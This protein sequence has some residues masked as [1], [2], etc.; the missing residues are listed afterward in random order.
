MQQKGTAMLTATIRYVL[1]SLLLMWMSAAAPAATLTVNCGGHTGFGSINAALKALQAVELRGPNT[2]NVSGACHENV[3]VQNLNDLTLNGLRGASITDASF[4][5]AEVLD[6]VDSRGFTLNGFTIASTCPAG[7]TAPDAI[8]CYYGS[9]CV[10]IQNTISGASGGSGIGVYALSRVRVVGGAVHD[11]ATGLFATDSGQMMALGVNVRGN[12]QGAALIRG[13]SLLF[14]GSEDH[15][16]PGVIANNQA[17][18]IDATDGSTVTVAGPSSITGNGAEGVHLD[19]GSKL[20]LATY[21]APVSV[22]G[23][24]GAGV[25]LDDLSTARFTGTA[26]VSGNG[27]PDIAC[28]APTAVTR[29]A[30][31]AAGG[32]AHTNCAN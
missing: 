14:G 16:T 25:S 11:N 17:Q 4:G 19:L 5:V 20:V 30:L 18:G 24:A 29:R 28:N 8:S 13:G 3:V 7:C 22:S 2:V 12:G 1:A 15:L 21:Y 6:V 27:Q 32:A 9:D 23:N 10:L 26:Q 31:V